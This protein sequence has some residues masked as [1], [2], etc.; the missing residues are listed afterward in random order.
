MIYQVYKSLETLLRLMMYLGNI[1]SQGDAE[2]IYCSEDGAVKK[3]NLENIQLPTT[4]I[5]KRSHP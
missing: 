4:L 5:L 1:S 2:M 3:E